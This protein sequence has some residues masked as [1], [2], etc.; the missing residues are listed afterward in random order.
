MDQA[1]RDELNK[2]LEVPANALNEYQANFICARRS[3]L[4][5]TQREEYKDVITAHDEALKES[6]KEAQKA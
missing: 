3:Y 2:I 1:S 4:N 5:K 6:V